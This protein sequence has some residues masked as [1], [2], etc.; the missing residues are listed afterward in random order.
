[1]NI[2]VL[3]NMKLMP[4]L[5]IKHEAAHLVIKLSTCLKILLLGPLLWKAN[6]KLCNTGTCAPIL[7]VLQRLTTF[8]AGRRPF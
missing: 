8:L 2:I 1:M 6:Y 3:M 7:I 5:Y 4:W